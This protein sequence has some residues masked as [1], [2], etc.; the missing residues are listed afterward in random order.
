MEGIVA[1]IIKKPYFLFRSLVRFPYS[2]RNF[3]ARKNPTLRNEIQSQPIFSTLFKKKQ[4][5]GSKDD[6]FLLI[7]GT[8]M[9]IRKWKLFFSYE[10]FSLLR[11][12]DYIIR[13]TFYI[14]TAEQW[15]F[16]KFYTRYVFSRFIVLLICFVVCTITLLLKT[17]SEL[18]YEDSNA[19]I[20]F[21]SCKLT[22]AAEWEIPAK[23]FFLIILHR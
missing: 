12:F 2:W 4:R 15:S 3:R 20:I 10:N 16:S 22:R 7:I 8:D 1:E 23:Y 18:N 13:F 14:K 11:V 17:G 21:A 6:E 9:S 5:A 19:R